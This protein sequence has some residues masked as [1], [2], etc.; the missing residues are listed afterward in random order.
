VF[1]GVRRLPSRLNTNQ[2]AIWDPV[3]DT[4]TEAGTAHGTVPPTKVGNSDEESWV[5]LPD[6]TVAVDGGALVS[7]F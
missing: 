3:F 2:T 7:I 5:L 4:W 6:G 1:A